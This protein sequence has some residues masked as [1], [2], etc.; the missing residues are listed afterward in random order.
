[1]SKQT[2]ALVGGAGR[3]GTLI[4]NALLDKP[5]VQLRPLSFF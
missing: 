3:L 4:G 1:M 2:I 5:D